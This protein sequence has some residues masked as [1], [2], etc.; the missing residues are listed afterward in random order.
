MKIIQTFACVTLT[1]VS[2]KVFPQ[3]AISPT[4]EKYTQAIQETQQKSQQ[5]QTVQA[6]ATGAQTQFDVLKN[7][8]LL[9]KTQ[10]EA[11]IAQTKTVTENIMVTKK[12][13]QDTKLAVTKLM[14]ELLSGAEKAVKNAQTDPE[15][16]R[17]NELQTRITQAQKTLSTA[18]NQLEQNIAAGEALF[19][20]IK[21][22][23]PV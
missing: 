22:L 10:K 5:L 12:N 1:F 20:Q 23:G 19:A 14:T 21:A 13:I 18:L 7:Q 17:A 16:A 6:S 11:L 2:Q 15:R 9:L 8:L 4:Y 3:T